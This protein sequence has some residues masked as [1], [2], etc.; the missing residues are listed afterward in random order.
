MPPI[1]TEKKAPGDQVKPGTKQAAENTCGKCK[2]TGRIDDKPCP[3]CGGSGKVVE[4]VG[5]A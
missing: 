5:D 1:D 3:D 4:I 2:G